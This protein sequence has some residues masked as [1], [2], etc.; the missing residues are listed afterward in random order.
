MPRRAARLCAFPSCPE[1]VEVG[2]YC[3]EHRPVEKRG[4]AA[5]RGYGRQWQK[6]RKRQLSV[7]PLCADPRG[8][9]V[10]RVVVATEAHHMIA[11]RNGGTN[12]LS[13]LQ[14]LCKPCHSYETV[15]ETRGGRGG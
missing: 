3:A 14:S 13:N 4:S 9:H 10:G 11:L 5:K 12:H 15:R 1:I 8:R 2:G 7:S 6:V